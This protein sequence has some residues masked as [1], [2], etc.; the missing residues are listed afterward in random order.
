MK[1]LAKDKKTGQTKE[2]ILP[3]NLSAKAV[4]RIKERLS[5]GGLS[6]RDFSISTKQANK[7]YKP[8]DTDITL[9]AT[10]LGET[11]AW[12]KDH[13]YFVRMVASDTT[14][15]MQGDKFSES[16][17]TALGAQYADKWIE[18]EIGGRTQC[19]MHDRDCMVGRTYRSEIQ[20]ATDK[21]GN[22]KL[23]ENGNTI[24]ELVVYAYVSL[25]AMWEG[26]PVVNYIRDGRLCKVSISA[27]I[28]GWEYI[29]SENS[30][31]IPFGE[32]EPMGYF[33]YPDGSTV[34]AIELSFVDMGA[35]A[36]AHVTKQKMADVEVLEETTQTTKIEPEE[37]EKTEKED[38]V[39]T[40]KVESG[41]TDITI[42]IAEIETMKAYYNAL[43][44]S[45][46]KQVITWVEVS[47]KN[48]GDK[49]SFMAPDWCA[50]KFVNMDRSLGKNSDLIL[51]LQ[52]KVSELESKVSEGSEK[53]ITL[54]HDNE[55]LQKAI[56]QKD[57]CV[58]ELT[59]SL[60]Q[61]S[62]E[63]ETIREEYLQK[64]LSLSCQYENNVTADFM[65]AKRLIAKNFTVIELR[66]K[67]EALLPLLLDKRNTDKIQ[68]EQEAKKKE[69]KW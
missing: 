14:I 35:N 34:E 45:L 52:N 3:D 18:A 24:R 33:F 9:V 37:T 63:L 42:N 61:T 15:D 56:T 22:V 50:T 47:L 46:R 25:T 40:A 57:A 44:E 21:E 62:K 60:N 29:S 36:N 11:E 17:I 27:W 7:A 58:S 54:T 6:V 10:G 20:D 66:E 28:S 41:T 64:F 4:Q 13:F 19:V 23:D 39:E 48:H 43:P 32:T 30:N 38:K 26:E 1:F 49:K 53:V 69:A 31:W 16:V 51:E 8:V 65:E 5:Y 59:S 12:V 68:L 2:H 55:D 67:V